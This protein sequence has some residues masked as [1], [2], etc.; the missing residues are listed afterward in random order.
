MSIPPWHVH[1]SVAAQATPVSQEAATGNERKA[2]RGIRFH[3]PHQL[4][5][6]GLAHIGEIGGVEGEQVIDAEVDVFQHLADDAIGQGV[7]MA[8]AGG[9]EHGFQGGIAVGQVIEQANGGAVE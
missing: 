7:G 3:L 6:P 9:V 1:D 8:D 5:S 4:N 2:G